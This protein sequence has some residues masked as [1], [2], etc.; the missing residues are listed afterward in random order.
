MP[1]FLSDRR[2]DDQSRRASTLA[3][4]DARKLTEVGVAF[5]LKLVVDAYLRSVVGVRHSGFQFDRD[6]VNQ[7]QS[8]APLQLRLVFKRLRQTPVNVFGDLRG[9][10]AG[11]MLV[12]GNDQLAQLIHHREL[13]GS[14]KEMRLGLSLRRTSAVFWPSLRQRRSDDRARRQFHHL[15]TTNSRRRIFTPSPIA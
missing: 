1:I 10:R 4:V 12:G 9:A 3:D 2:S 11:R 14:E 15:A 5:V 8:L 13:I 6:L 7:L